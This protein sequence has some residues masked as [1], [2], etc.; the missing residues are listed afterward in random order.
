[1]S[2]G[3]YIGRNHSADGHAWLAGYGDEPSSHWLEIVDRAEHPEGATITVGVGPD[4]D[5]PGRRT[6][7]PQARHTARHMRVS[8]SYYLGVPAPI[9]NGGLNEHGVAVRDIW[10]TSS[11]AL[12][13]M[14]PKD[15][16][17]PNY[18]DLARIVVER[19]KTAREG[20]DLIAALIA[21]HGYSC[22][23][24]NSHIIADPD[25]AWVVIQFSGGLGLWVAE[26]LG[27]DSIRASRPGYIGVVPTEPDET[28]LY[29]PHFIRTAVEHGWYDPAGGAPFDVNAIYGDGK[30]RWDG[31][32]WI[33]AEMRA[34]AAAAPLTFA[35]VAWAIQT[36]VLTGDTA[37]YGQ[38]VPLVHPAHDDLRTM[39]HAPVGPVTAPLVPVFLG[40]TEVPDAYAQHRYLTTGESHR[41]L[42]RRKEPKSPEVVSHVPQGI[43]VSDSAVYEFKRLMHLAFQD[44][45]LLREVWDHWRGMEADLAADL[46]AVLR[47]AELLLDAGEATL[48]RRLLT[49][50]S[51][52]WLSRALDDCH[53]L[54][55]SGYVRLRQK[56]RLNRAGKPLSP[57]QRW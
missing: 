8:Y 46:P 16:T 49:R 24:G 21:E 17:G 12:I 43:E 50:E 29:P 28:F 53:A 25:E 22:Y 9:T 20:V 5:M 18:S 4:S 13:A 32:A 55:A 7:I 54:V 39:W 56:G 44:D 42:D 30:G 27:P 37:G 3:I 40:Q 2:Y 52:A 36:E 47:S 34:R 1:M 10:S 23:G 14:T 11:D 33:E 19:A 26:R 31:M 57:A 41:F 35:D 15:Q 48:A 45:A 6:E 51:G 38:V